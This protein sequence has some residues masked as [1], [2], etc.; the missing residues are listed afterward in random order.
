MENC[1][2]VYH[3]SY[4]CWKGY[5]VKQFRDTIYVSA[6]EEIFVCMKR[7]SDCRVGVNIT[8]IIFTC[9]FLYTASNYSV[10]MLLL[11]YYMR[12]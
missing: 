1:L 7:V 6:V 4:M 3:G 10:F 12:E 9:S 5:C 11:F 8:I 2:T